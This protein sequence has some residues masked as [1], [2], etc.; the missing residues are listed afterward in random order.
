MRKLE[1]SVDY[2]ITSLAISTQYDNVTDRQTDTARSAISIGAF[3]TRRAVKKNELRG[4]L[5]RRFSAFGFD[6][7]YATKPVRRRKS[8]G[9][10]E[11]HILTMP[12]S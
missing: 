7:G 4:K 11:V 8:L 2:M 12:L 3:H 10:D 6:I 9:G 1:S 5:Q